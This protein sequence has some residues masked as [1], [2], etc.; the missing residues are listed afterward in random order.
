MPGADISADGAASL[1]GLPD[2]TALLAEL[3]GANLLDEPSPGRFTCH[4]L[5]RDYAAELS[6]ETERAQAQHRLLDHLAFTGVE[7]AVAMTQSR[8]RPDTTGPV[9]GAVVRTPASHDE[10]IRWLVTEHPTLMAA[11]RQ[12]TPAQTWLIG[13][14]LADVLDRIGHYQDLLTSQQLAVEALERLDRPHGL[15]RTLINLGRAHGRLNQLTESTRALERALEVAADDPATQADV[16][17]NLAMLCPDDQTHQAIEYTRRALALYEE[18][19]NIYGQANALNG[20][21]WTHGK[22]GE[23]EPA[24]AYG[25]R[26]MVLWQQL[27]HPLGQGE[28]WDNFATVHLVRGDHAA[29][30]RAW[31]K[32]IELYE[33]G[34]DRML[35][36][37]AHDQLGDAHAAAG[38]AEEAQ[39]AWRKAVELF[40]AADQ[41]VG[42]IQRKL[43][44]ERE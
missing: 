3:T 1:A 37:Q 41:P 8:R 14:S 22:L 5:L 20:L 12:G 6:Q 17:V 18:S 10:A 36:A 21:S 31:S 35:N 2:V 19:G 16:L 39:L 34:G 13:W 43:Q 30:V 9:E 25:E 28:A 26:A 33:R 23:A 4:D 40:R 7:M 15:A 11:M 42:H 24:L 27:D 44:A 38:A 32:A 29:A